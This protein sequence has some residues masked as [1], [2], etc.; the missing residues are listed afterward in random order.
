MG[1]FQDKRLTKDWL[2]S[3]T[4]AE[5]GFHVIGVNRTPEKVEVINQGGCYLKDLDIDERVSRVVRS[6][7]L[8]A[9]TDTAEATRKSD[10]I[11]ITVPTPITSDKKPDLSHVVDA[12]QGIARGLDNGKLVVLESTVYPG[13]TEEI[14][15]PLS[16]I[17]I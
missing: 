12:G 1:H 13:V 15:Q 5:H 11:V 8:E 9:T 2:L 10:A 6:K 14:L 4:I 7:N 17:H 16:L 3:V